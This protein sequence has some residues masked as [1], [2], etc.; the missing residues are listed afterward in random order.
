MCTAPFLESMSG[1]ANLNESLRVGDN[2]FSPVFFPADF[3]REFPRGSIPHAAVWPS[4]TV[5]H[6][7]GFDG[8]PR[9]L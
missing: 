7:P 9:I 1:W 6:P 3:R 8:P 2:V 4:R 5:I